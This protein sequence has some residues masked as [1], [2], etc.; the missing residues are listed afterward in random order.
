MKRTILL[1]CAV[2]T[3]ATGAFA[4][5]MTPKQVM[6]Q[7]RQAYD[8]V[9]SLRATVQVKMGET[10]VAS[11]QFLRPKQFSV[12]VT[13]NGKLVQSFTSD[14]AT[15]T[16][17]DAQRKTYTQQ[18]VS[19]DEPLAGGHLNFAGFAAIA[20]EPQF[21]QMLEGFVQKS[22]NKAQS[23]GTQKVG[24]TPC[25]VVELTGEEGTMTL[26]LGQKD[27]LV[28]R[29]VYKMADG[30]TYEELVTAL[31]LNTPVQKTVFAFKPPADAKKVEP[32]QQAEREDT[33]SLKGQQA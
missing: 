21:G 32:R 22:F 14:G 29:M 33:T 30:D 23:K 8:K 1:V 6:Q 15:F 3:L 11:V 20:M 19:K 28:Y 9:Q 16:T 7:I 2:C 24:A 10:F 5:S 27:G 26:F 17:Y 13:Q 18:P 12:Q 31:Q 25:R 4:Q